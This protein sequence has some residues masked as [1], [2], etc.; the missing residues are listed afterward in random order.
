MHQE[1]LY[2]VA[3][4]RV[5]FREH[6]HNCD[7]IEMGSLNINGSVRQMFSSCQYTGVDIG[8]GP[9]VDLISRAADVNLPLAD[10]IISCEMLEHDEDWQRSLVRMVELLRPGGLLVLSCAT[11]GRPEHGTINTTPEDAPYCGH[12]YR[13]LTEE[14]IRSAIDIDTLFYPAVFSGNPVT[15]DLYFFGKKRRM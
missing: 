6:F 9:G 3:A 15:R 5:L 11:T 8:P 12:Y 10:T 14:D 4:T 2:F 1:Q 7:V 13:N